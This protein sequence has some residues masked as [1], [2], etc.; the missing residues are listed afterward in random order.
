M[1]A[2]GF[3]VIRRAR[4]VGAV[5][6]WWAIDMGARYI[7]VAGMLY[8]KKDSLRKL[9]GDI[10]EISF[11]KPASFAEPTRGGGHHAYQGPGTVDA[12]P[13]LE[14]GRE[15]GGV[16]FLVEDLYR[17]LMIKLESKHRYKMM[18]MVCGGIGVTPMA[19]I[20]N[21]LLHEHHRADGGM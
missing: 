12:P 1:I 13:P 14:A 6:L 15:A 17:K 16:F 20:A 8:P 18:L 9:P 21:D 4:A 19:S 5:L 2:G 10:M 7:F 11:P 3:A